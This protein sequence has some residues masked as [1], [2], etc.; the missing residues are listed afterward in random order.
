MKAIAPIF[1]LTLLLAACAP[2]RLGSPPN[3]RPAAPTQANSR[4]AGQPNAA[5]TLA[6]TSG[7][8]ETTAPLTHTEIDI[9]NV[10]IGDGKVATSAQVGYVYSCQTS[11]NGGGAFQSGDWIHTDGTFD[12]SAKPTVDG[13]V[14]W[15][16]SFTITLQGDTRVI[17]SNDLP[18]HPAGQFPVSQSDDAYQYDRNPNS[19]QSQSISWNLPANPTL[20]ASPT[21]VSL[22]AIGIMKTGTVLFNALDAVGRDAVAHELQDNCGGHPES[23]GTYHYH[24]LTT[25]ISD[26][27]TGHSN[28]L[29]YA[30]DGFGIYGLR[31]ENGQA[32]TNA[33]LDA[34]HGHTHVIEWDGQQV[35]M[36]HYHMTNE[37]PYTI[38]CYMGTP[39][40]SGQGGGGGRPG[41]GNL[42]SSQPPAGA[43]PPRP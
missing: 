30:L 32:L 22:G 2:P 10:P 41:G 26:P 16:S 25:C 43:P 4:P 37:Y 29:G 35:T 17:A 5:P 8:I 33:D 20:A 6:P 24:A 3:S 31:G 21:C 28:L 15:P 40:A 38:G 27:G 11:F 39:V 23:N 9:H 12:P 18:N 19:I 13:S 1:I 7:L 42:P 36:Y 34:C 14:T